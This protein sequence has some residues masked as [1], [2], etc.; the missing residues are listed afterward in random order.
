M[1][2][3]TVM[4]S[5]LSRLNFSIGNDS[6]DDG[7]LAPIAPIKKSKVKKQPRAIEDGCIVGEDGR[8][9]EIVVKWAGENG[10][11]E[12]I[13]VPLLISLRIH[14]LFLFL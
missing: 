1:E 13:V 9:E 3:G 2:C 5:V 8:G 12:K 4:G 7:R 10:A 14:H 6:D 11:G